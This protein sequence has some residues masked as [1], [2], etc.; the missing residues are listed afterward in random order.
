RFSQLCPGCTRFVNQCP[1]RI[2]IP[3]LNVNLGERLNQKEEQTA[4]G[5]ALSSVTG[6]A[7]DDR[8]APVSKMFFGN[9]HYFAKWGTRFASISNALGGGGKITKAG[10][11][12]EEEEKVS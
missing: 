2:D 12:A 10:A 4:L 11:K 1:V 5:N 9:Y 6:A 3:W 7:Q 8:R